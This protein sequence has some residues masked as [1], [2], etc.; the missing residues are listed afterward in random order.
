MGSDDRA[1]DGGAPRRSDADDAGEC[2]LDTDA[3]CPSEM[4]GDE[5]GCAL[6]ASVAQGRNPGSARGVRDDADRLDADI[7]TVEALVARFA[8]RGTDGVWPEHSHF[9]RLNGRQWGVFCYRH[10]D[11]HLR[12]FGA[13]HRTPRRTVA[14]S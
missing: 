14:R 3:S 7:A 12:Q 2:A 10:F 9:G 1:P 8:A 6:L 11:H 13:E 4:A 5:A